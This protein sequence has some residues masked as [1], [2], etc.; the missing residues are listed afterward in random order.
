M[1]IEILKGFEK[2][3]GASLIDNGVNFAVFAPN[4]EKIEICIFE[5]D[6]QIASFT[7]PYQTNGI[8]HGLIKGMEIRKYGIRAYGKYDVHNGFYYNPNKLLLDPYSLE[9]DGPINLCESHFSHEY[10]SP[11]FLKD[12]AQD[13]PKTII[14]S[15]KIAFPKL[16]I[17][18]E[19]SIIYEL[20]IKGFSQNNH[21]INPEIR[22]KFKALADDA[23]IKYFKELGI[24]CIEIMPCATW[25]DEAHLQK[26]GLSN[27]WGYNPICHM[28]PDKKYAPNGWQDIL[29]TTKKLE[30]NG[31]ETIIDVVFNHSGEGDKNGPILSYRGLDNLNYY[32][33]QNN[34]YE[35]SSGCGNV[36]ACDRPHNISLFIETMRAWRKYGG[37]HGFRFDLASIMG[38]DE[39]GF[40]KYAALFMAILN[41]EELSKLKLIAEPWD[42]YQYNIGEFPYEFAEWN[43]KFRDNMRGFWR[44]ERNFGDFAKSFCGSQDIFFN[45]GPAKSINYIVA[46]D[47]FSLFD[48]V[49]FEKKNN[50]AN[51]ENNQDGTDNNLSFNNG[52]EGITNDEA[53]IQNRKKN[54]RIHSTCLLLSRGTPMILMGS[55]M[56]KTQYGNNN[57]YAQDN[58]ISYLD[59][60]NFDTEIFEFTKKLIEIRKKHPC[61][62]L[63][64]FFKGEIEN[65]YSDISWFNQNGG[66]FDAHEWNDIGQKFLLICIS[67]ENSRFLIAINRGDEEINYKLPTPNDEHIWEIIIDCETNPKAQNNLIDAA[68]ISARNIQILAQLQSDKPIKHKI[69]SQTLNKIC[70]ILG[71]SQY[72]HDVSG[73]ESQAPIATIEAIAKSLGF[74]IS[75]EENAIKT[76]NLIANQ[77]DFR[78][79]PFHKSFEIDEAIQIDIIFPNPKLKDLILEAENSDKQICDIQNLEKIELIAIDGRKISKS[80][81]IINNLSIGHYKLYFANDVENYCSITIAPKTCYFPQSFEGKKFFGLSAQ[82]YSIS[83]ENDQGIGD[84]TTIQ[85]LMNF[86]EQNGANILAINPLHALFQNSRDL[87]SPY[88]PS[89]RCF[90]E[91]LY[92][93]LGISFKN[94]NIHINYDEIWQKKQKYLFQEFQN[95]QNNQDFKVFLEN[96]DETLEAF[97]IFEVLSKFF[98][99]QNWQDWPIEY[100]SKN[101]QI[102]KEFKASHSNEIQFQKYLQFKCENQFAA[103]KNH[104]MEIGLCRDLAIGSAPNGAEAWINFEYMAQDVSIG[105]PP[106]PLGPNGQNWGLPP[107]NPI[108]LAQNHFKIYSDLFNKNMKNAGALRIDHAMGLMR[109]FWVPKDFNGNDG[110]YINFPFKD[111]MAELKLAS[112]QNQC[113][114]IAED[115]GTL[116]H[117]F[118]Q[119]MNDAMA[120]SY[121]VLPFEKHDNGFKPASNY[122]YFGFACVSTHDLPP[123]LGWWKS[124][125]II[126]RYELGLL[127]NSQYE[128]EK[129]A[130]QNEKLQ[131]IQLLENENI[132]QSKIDINQENCPLDLNIA[133]HEFIARSNSFLAIAQFEDIAG[134]EL[135]INL[136]G[137]NTERPNWSNYIAKKLEEIS[138]NEALKSE[139]QSIIKAISKNRT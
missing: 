74:D 102:I 47:G 26:L 134:V 59:W 131:I 130:R 101:P 35:N 91:P 32:R 3:L 12:S 25:V 81:L 76:L 122:P 60:Q 138:G 31:I 28:A 21:K 29:E 45:K 104:K 14:C 110:T 17:P 119:I 120:L 94:P 39:N 67:H 79:L 136:P 61:F 70:N 82:I 34:E 80:R 71:I 86:A 111:L 137:T 65:L 9:I 52:F 75:S 53:I 57:A 87:K 19:E 2:P 114:I 107:Y 135:P 56:G 78:P 127:T 117:G 77:N 41:D 23:A 8:F 113:I 124:L 1:K 13:T 40:D 6:C 46:H 18:L 11:Q 33:V 20:H 139:N 63:N 83:R 108:K 92:I 48:L 64:Q 44:N 72:W 97:A 7:L 10:N 133:M 96:H 4:A 55:E 129:A 42:C 109:Q 15:P 93:D 84:F 88:Y 100:K 112:H 38:R 121:K 36:F 95:Q 58:E 54:V 37:V 73:K 27:Y 103:T 68:N 116:P 126:E 85:K 89:H 69:Q 51:G 98:N 16:N 99:G 62:H 132:L 123:I 125:D 5:N 118:S 49:S 106:D 66:I 115:L 128:I 43:D 105:A 30:E 50:F 24:N 90:L 22:G